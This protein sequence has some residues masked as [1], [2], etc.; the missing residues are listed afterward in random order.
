MGVSCHLSKKIKCDCKCSND[1][2]EGKDVSG[3][4]ELHTKVVTSALPALISVLGD[5][6]QELGSTQLARE[7]SSDVKA[8]S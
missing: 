1:V 7:C 6:L 5:S 8:M 3:A 4:S 2:T